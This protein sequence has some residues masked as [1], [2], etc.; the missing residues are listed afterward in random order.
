MI[1][2]PYFNDAALDHVSDAINDAFQRIEM[3]LGAGRNVVIP[4]DGLGTGLADL[5]RRAPRIHRYIEERIA[6]LERATA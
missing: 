1:Q 2:W 3:A 4:A 5:P 6:K